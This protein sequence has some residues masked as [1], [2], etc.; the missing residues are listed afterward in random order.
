MLQTHRAEPAMSARQAYRLVAFIMLL[1]GSS[2]LVVSGEIGGPVIQ[3]S[4][5][6]TLISVDLQFADGQHVLDVEAQQ[7]LDKIGRMLDDAILYGRPVT[8]IGHANDTDYI[9]LNWQL[10]KQRAMNVRNYLVSV[11]G[12]DLQRLSIA[13]KADHYPADS[14]NIKAHFNRR[15]EFLS[16]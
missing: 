5:Q 14:A 4:P 16:Q 9:D 3:E 1:L 6:G 12:I 11:H 8:I 15:I 7:L 10:A 13:A 2:M